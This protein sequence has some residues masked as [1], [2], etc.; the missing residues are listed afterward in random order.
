[1]ERFRNGGQKSLEKAPNVELIFGEAHFAGGMRVEVKLK[2]RGTRELEGKRI[3]VNTGGRPAVPPI[4][5]LDQIP[6]LD[7]TSIMELT[8]VPEHLVVLGGGYIGLEFCQMFRRFGARVT[9]INRDPRLVLR[10]DPDVSGGGEKIPKEDGIK[11]RNPGQGTR[12]QRRG[13][14][15]PGGLQPA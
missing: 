7:S 8:K 9:I 1:V 6:Y 10:E 13:S 11:G 12:V 15:E 3:V 14:G 4:P 2:R 5:G